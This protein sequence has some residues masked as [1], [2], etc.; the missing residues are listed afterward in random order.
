[1]K[2]NPSFAIA[3][4]NLGSAKKKNN[5]IKGAIEDYTFAIKLK[6]DYFI[7]YDNRGSARFE[8]G[9]YAG[10]IEDYTETIKL[11]S[12]YALAYNNRGNAYLKNANTDLAKATPDFQK[13]LADYDKAIKLNP[14]Y[15]YAYY[16]RGIIKEL[17]RQ[18]KAACADWAKAA[19]LGINNAAEII[20]TECK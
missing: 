18:Q 6:P 3:Y 2:L 16:N 1:V 20:K 13:A 19:E 4:N 14:S 7:A 9:D 10:A 17:L 15:G 12:E 8:L 5:D 11:N